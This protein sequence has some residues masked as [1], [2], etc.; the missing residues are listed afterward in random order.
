MVLTKWQDFINIH[1][2]FSDIICNIIILS[3]N[4]FATL[5]ISFIIIINLIKIVYT[6]FLL[7]KKPEIFE[8]KNS[9]LNIFATQV[10]KILSCIK[11]GCIATGST[12]AVVAGG[13][14]FDTLIEKTVA[15]QELQYLFH[16]WLK[17]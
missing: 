7:K 13:I 4:I 9:P 10:A 11:I 14:T 3:T 16:L 5:F 15:K 6:I 12:G 2:Y 17:V 1:N 8:V